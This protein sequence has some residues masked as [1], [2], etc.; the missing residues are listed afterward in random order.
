LQH[1]EGDIEIS[2]FTDAQGPS[3]YPNNPKP[4]LKIMNKKP[5]KPKVTSILAHLKGIKENIL[6]L[7]LYH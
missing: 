2:L 7:T 6:S 1:L 5:K 3:F 4:M